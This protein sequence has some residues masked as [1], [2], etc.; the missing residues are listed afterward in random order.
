MI[1]QTLIFRRDIKVRKGKLI[2]QG[3]HG[4]MMFLSESLRKSLWSYDYGSHV[5][6]IRLTYEQKAWIEGLFTK[7]CLVVDDEA[8]MLALYEKAVEAGLTAHLVRDAGL[9]EFHGVPTLTCLAIGP[10][11]AERI[12]AITAGLDLF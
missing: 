9:T 8:A 1:K 4:A 12:D 11:E 2:S 5:Y 7:I 10:H 6:T 3:A